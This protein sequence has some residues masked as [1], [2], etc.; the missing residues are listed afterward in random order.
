MAQVSWPE[1]HPSSSGG[2]EAPTAQERQP[3]AEAEAE[4]TPEDT[5]TATPSEA[6]EEGDDTVDTDYAADMAEAQSTW[7][8]CP[9]LA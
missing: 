6:P 2:G 7:D 8:P 5:P 4:E 3:E 9:T 1:V